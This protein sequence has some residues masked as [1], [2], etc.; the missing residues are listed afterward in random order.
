M[1]R[2]DALDHY[3]YF[4]GTA[5]SVSRQLA[6][7]AIAIVWIFRT[8]TENGPSLANDLLLPAALACLA[9]SCDLLQYISGA[10]AWGQFHRS[11]EKARHG[12]DHDIGQ[13]PRGINWAT[14]FFFIV[15]LSAV[16]LGY[17]VLLGYLFRRV[18]EN[19]M[20]ATLGAS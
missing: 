14:N 8:E 3:E 10:I 7:A 12:L 4:S 1:K 19:P 5:S 13:A 2:R 16:V 6:F 20:G 11:K 9:L 18:F 17:V 15:K